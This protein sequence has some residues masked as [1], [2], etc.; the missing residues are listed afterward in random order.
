MY[1]TNIKTTG[2]YIS[3]EVK[4]VVT[5]RFLGGGSVLDIAVIFDISSA[6][7]RT[8]IF[9]LLRDWMMKTG[10]GDINMVKYLGPEAEMVKVSEGF[11]KISTGGFKDD[12]GTLDR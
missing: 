9:P 10:V 2:G 4:I 1:D 7:L 5:C 12:V 8:L 11:S 6:H 3:T